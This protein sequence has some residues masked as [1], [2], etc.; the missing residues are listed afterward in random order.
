EG[1]DGLEDGFLDQADDAVLESDRES[2]DLVDAA[3]DDLFALFPER[4]EG[5]DIGDADALDE[6]LDLVP[7][8]AADVL[9]RVELRLRP[10]ADLVEDAVVVER[11]GDVGAARNQLDG[12][13]QDVAGA[14][15][16]AVAGDGVE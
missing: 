10:G 12:A 16:H 3:G 6:G 1:A 5:A 9:Q 15:V 7:D 2:L 13:A 11:L 8:A 14:A 4:V